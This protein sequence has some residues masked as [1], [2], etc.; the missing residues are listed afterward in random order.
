MWKKSIILIFFVLFSF[1][2]SKKRTNNIT[3]NDLNY[4][5]AEKDS[6][7]ILQSAYKSI[8]FTVDRTLVPYND[9]LSC[10]SS[11]V[12]TN[13][14]FPAG[15]DW[16]PFVK[17]EG[18]GW[19]ANAVGGAFEIYSFGDYF[20]DSN[21]VNKALF[22]LDHILQDG[23]INDSTGFIIGYRNVDSDS[24]FLNYTH[25][26]NWFCV[27]SMAKI[28]YQLLVFSDLVDHERKT[29]MQEIAQKNAAWII[30]NVQM[31]DN[32]WYPRRSTPSGANF[33]QRPE[34]GDDPLFDKSADGLFILQLLTEL[35]QRGL[36]D[37]RDHIREK[38]NLFIKYGGIFGS[39][40]H[41]TYDEHENVAYSVAFRVLRKVSVLLKDDK[42]RSFAFDKCLKG[43]EQFKIKADRNG[44]QCAGLYIMEKNWDTAYLWENA[45][46]ALAFLEAYW[47][48][49]DESYF[50]EAHS[51]L[52]AISKH[53]YGEY[54][55]LTE[56]VDWN[57]HVGAQHHFNDAEFGDIEYTEPFLN[58]LH[59]VE[60][61]LIMLKIMDKRI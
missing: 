59:I 49:K 19:A 58:N 60:P 1:A 11:F 42:I 6:S 5:L 46:A 13:G 43:L 45:E 44:V 39:I 14:N 51:I 31:A 2:C 34:G 52:K 56:G 38:A 28:A 22:V 47:D 16:H 50:N 53:H 12:D 27:G 3:K 4:Y 21:L 36:G 20:G 30:E 40:N 37:Y 29:K 15:L 8:R 24:F 26:K 61:T 48:T 32:G 33:T 41:D 57:N 35:T 9:H 7:G 18:P 25:D 10:K 55:F 17:L 54:G 23:F